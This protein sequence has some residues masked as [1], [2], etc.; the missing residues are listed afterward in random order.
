MPTPWESELAGFLADLSAVQDDTLELLGRKRRL[1]VQ[2]DTQALEA[3]APEE[4]RLQERLQ[5]CLVRREQLLSRAGEEGLPSASITALAKAL[6]REQ[7]QGLAAP[8]QT[9]AARMRLLQHESLTNWVLVQRTLL[10]LSQLL[11]IIATGG[12]L[13]PTYGR[14]EPPPAGGTLVD[15]AA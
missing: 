11:E 7:R 15:S 14:G 8:M 13:Q 12:R 3:M 1:L 10:H 5:Q 2:V 4:Q 6:P 9:A